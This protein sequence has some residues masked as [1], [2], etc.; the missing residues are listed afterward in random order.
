VALGWPGLAHGAAE[1]GLVPNTAEKRAGLAAGAGE[2]GY[3]VLPVSPMLKVRPEQLPAE[4]PAPEVRLD[5][6]RGEAENRQLLVVPLR[7]DLAGVSVTASFDSAATPLPTPELERVCYV[8]VDHPTA[9]GFRQP[10]RYPDALF[11]LAPLEVKLGEAQAVWLTLRVPADTAPGEYRGRIR[12]APTNAPAVELPLSVAVHAVTLPRPGKLRSLVLVYDGVPWYNER[13]GEA[14]DSIF[15]RLLRERFTPTWLGLPWDG[16]F[17]QDPGRGWTADWQA[18]DA[19]AEAWIA[20]GATSFWLPTQPFGVG[21]ELTQDPAV[22]AA[23]AAKLRLLDQHLVARHW[24]GL[25]YS[26]AFDEPP[27]DRVPAISRY[28]AFLREHAPHVMIPITSALR[29]LSGTGTAWVPHIHELDSPDHYAFLMRQRRHGDDIWMYT[30][31]GTRWAKH[32]DNWRIDNYGASH[33]ALGWSLWRHACQGYL[34]WNASFWKTGE[35]D[36]QVL[37]DPLTNPAIVNDTNYPDGHCNGDG[38]LF[39]PDP[40]GKDL[41][42]PSIRLA[43]T[44]DGFED[45]DLL[46][47]LEDRLRAVRS[48]SALHEKVGAARIAA[49][50]EALNPE[51]LVKAGGEYERDPEAYEARHRQL[52]QAIAELSP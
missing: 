2:A 35:G 6:A 36:K 19:A 28:C 47:L 9:V 17:R 32:P 22:L 14:C 10:G 30:C 11:S 5:A 20:K 34:Y 41:P 43:L 46:W 25:F 44:R 24:E 21:L 8:P 27:P 18:F 31:M 38:F 12:F 15:Q 42:Y 50:V 48:N 37:Y 7:Q 4:A 26:Y 40:Q 51:A 3:A 23:A 39:Y 16:V 52:L 13:W 45:Y 29:S 49:G 33:R 1:D